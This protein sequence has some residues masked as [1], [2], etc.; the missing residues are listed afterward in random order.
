MGNYIDPSDITTWASACDAVCQE[1]AI[2]F[3][4]QLIEKALG[5]PFYPA[6]LDKRMNGNGKNR[7]FPPLSAPLLTVEH[8]YVCD[9]EIDPCWY[10]WDKGSIFLDMC[11]ACPSSGGL[12]ELWF[13]LTAEAPEGFFPRGY[14]NIRIVGTYGSA[15]VPEPLKQAIKI[16]IDAV[17]DGSYAVTGGFISE[18]IGKYSYRLGATGYVKDGVYTGLPSVDKILK[19][20]VKQ[21]RPKI[22]TP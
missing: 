11:K 18:S 9:I 20:Y 12:S 13:L 1:G 17:N 8:L 3:A 10:S 5:R 21:K 15:S 16:L 19:L 2:A 6:P 22:L 14:D 4:E 7:I